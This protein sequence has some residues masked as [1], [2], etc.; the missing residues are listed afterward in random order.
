MP[1]VSQNWLLGAG[2]LAALAGCATH[3]PRPIG[4]QAPAEAIREGFS[5]FRQQINPVGAIS[6]SYYCVFALEEASSYYSQSARSERLDEFIAGLGE[7]CRVGRRW[8][9]EDPRRT[10]DHDLGVIVIRI[11][12]GS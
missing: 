9:M 7:D 4:G 1:A 2:V 12:C 3:A 5:C 8:D 10:F 6:D 11:E